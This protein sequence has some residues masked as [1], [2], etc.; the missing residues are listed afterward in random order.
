MTDRPRE[1]AALHT[2]LMKCALE[3]EP[4]RA[5]WAHADG[6]KPA[7]P[8]R[9]FEEYWFGA[10]SL[11]W[12]GVLVANMRLRFDAYPAA[13]RVLHRWAHM[14][15]D[16]RRL[17]CHWHLQL[18]DPLYR[19]FSGRYLVDRRQGPRPAIT[20]DLV[21]EWMQEHGAEQWTLASRIQFASKLL[22]AAYAAGLI[23]T[24]RDPRPILVPRVP[25]D[26][27]EYVLY[28]LRDV[29]IEGTLLDNP[30]LTSV[31]L[32]GA[33]L[34]ARLRALP[35]MRFEK[36]GELMEIGWR[37]ADLGAWA[38]ATVLAPAS[39]ARSGAP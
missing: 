27:L 8:Q 18:A 33:D 16:T 19:A 14:S 39:A 3:I 2:R 37:H 23:G 9:A 35:G 15:P 13:L 38:E 10:R 36:Q 29:E 7:N 32:Q 24:N 6:V 4:A 20:R 21:V 17:I 1:Q 31:G 5:Y 30:Y 28:L 34:H 26:A 22:S 12:A 25:D 11:R